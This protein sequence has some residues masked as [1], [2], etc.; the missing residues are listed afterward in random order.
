MLEGNKPVGMNSFCMSLQEEPQGFCPSI[1]HS[2]GLSGST[3]PVD[4]TE[5][6]ATVSTD[7]IT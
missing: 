6:I 7:V 2:I 4:R 3:T 5:S 1:I